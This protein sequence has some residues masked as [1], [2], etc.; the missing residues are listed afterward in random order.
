MFHLISLKLCGAYRPQEV[1]VYAPHVLRR[2]NLNTS[3]QL[4]QNLYQAPLILRKEN[5]NQLIELEKCLKNV[6]ECKP[7]Q[8]KMISQNVLCE[9]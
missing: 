3:D 7:G 6:P 1:G 2:T 4:L 9:S 5:Q 8:S